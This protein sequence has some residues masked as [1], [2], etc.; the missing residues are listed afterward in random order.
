MSFENNRLVRV[1]S[2]DVREVRSIT[3]GK[4][5]LEKGPMPE[6]VLFLFTHPLF[7]VLYKSSPIDPSNLSS[8]SHSLKTLPNCNV[9]LSRD[10]DLSN[11]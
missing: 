7:T 8:Y 6:L 9:K 10:G 11:L 3:D 1:K 4:G 2:N 5:T